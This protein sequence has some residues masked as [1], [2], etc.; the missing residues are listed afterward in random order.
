MICEN[1]H[2]TPL[3]MRVLDGNSL[4][5]ISFEKMVTDHIEALNNTATGTVVSDSAIY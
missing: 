5:K 3:A 4:D 2:I 1:S